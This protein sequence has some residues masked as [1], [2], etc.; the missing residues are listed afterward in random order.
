MVRCCQRLAMETRVNQC[1]CVARFVSWRFC[2]HKF[3]SF[4]DIED[5]LANTIMVGEIN[6]DLGDNDITTQLSVVP[7]AQVADHPDYCEEQGHR[8]PNRPRFW[9][10]A[11]QRSWK[12]II[13]DGFA[14]ALGLHLCTGFNTIMPPNE[15]MC[16]SIGS[17]ISPLMGGV[18]PASSR[19]PGG[20]P[21]VDGRRCRS[22]CNRFD[23]RRQRP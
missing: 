3:T 7:L 5:G 11:T 23:R 10:P 20:C 1:R 15:G 6:T 12:S 17:V 18:T 19:H 8:D 2:R 4:R 16:G 13:G 21:C 14:W 22:I 9:G